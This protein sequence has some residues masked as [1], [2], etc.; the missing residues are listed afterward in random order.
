MEGVSWR[1]C[2]PVGDGT[3]WVNGGRDYCETVR[4]AGPRAA[5]PPGLVGYLAGR[6]RHSSEEE[7]A[8]MKNAKKH[9][10]SPLDPLSS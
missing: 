8:E 2:T 4:A 10:R 9:V 7:W 3:S 6:Y 1:C 5:A